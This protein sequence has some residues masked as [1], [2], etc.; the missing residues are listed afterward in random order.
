M[1]KLKLAVCMENG[2]YVKRFTNCLMNHYR[3]KIELHMFTDMKELEG[4]PLESYDVFLVSDFSLEDA[5]VAKI[6]KKKA[7]YLEESTEEGA[8]AE[9]RDE[10]CVFLDKYAG[11]PQIV[12]EIMMLFD[13]KERL[14][15]T[16]TKHASRTKRLAVYSLNEAYLQLP[17]AFC[18]ASILGEANKV[19]LVD[20]QENSGLTQ[21]NEGETVAG[22]EE[23]LA[24]VQ[25]EKYTKQRLVGGISHFRYW[26][27]LYPFRNSE[28]ISEGDGSSYE[29]L[30][31]LLEQ[32]QEYEVI[33]LNF[34]GRFQGFFQLMESC[35]SRYLLKK[36]HGCEWREQAFFKELEAKEFTG[37]IDGWNKIV[38]PA[39]QEEESQPELLSDQW[40]WGQIGETLRKQLLKGAI[41]G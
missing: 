14:I 10:D 8:G 29:K 6:L 41:C 27:Y 9:T 34:G 3:N 40:Q 32:E 7:I 4:I 21:F 2:E 18:M 15:R 16:E 37:L 22:M 36:N 5:M 13:N 28:C 20:L 33:I 31:Q 26:D 35:E 19:L 38:L 30:L 11:V 39:E 1:E 23:L 17:F 12:D 25:T 24:L